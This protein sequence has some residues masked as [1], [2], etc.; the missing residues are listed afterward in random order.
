MRGMGCG[1]G[2]S[3]GVCRRRLRPEVSVVV[4][5]SA[6]AGSTSLTAF[7]CVVCC[8]VLSVGSEA[9]DRVTSQTGAARTVLLVSRPLLWFAML[10]LIFL[11][12]Y[13]ILCF[14]WCDQ[15]YECVSST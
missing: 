12:F 14:V 5:L 11:F 10:Y 1:S 13:A 3:G 2:G 9:L 8:A 7:L 6:A 15:L 4:L